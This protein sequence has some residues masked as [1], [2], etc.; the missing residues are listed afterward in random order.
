LNSDQ[1]NRVAALAMERRKSVG[2]KDGIE[3]LK[4][5]ENCAD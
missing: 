1:V 5:P 4:A 3:V 2:F